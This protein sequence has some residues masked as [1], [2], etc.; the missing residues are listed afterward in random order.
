LITELNNRRVAI[1]IDSIHG[2]ARTA[3]TKAIKRIQVYYQQQ[4]LQIKST[5]S[6]TGNVNRK[7]MNHVC[8]LME[9]AVNDV[10]KIG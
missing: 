6:P 3:K 4:I 5:K 7:E 2:T 10:N 9:T 1:T 8:L